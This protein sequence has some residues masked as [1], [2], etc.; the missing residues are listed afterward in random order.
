MSGGNRFGIDLTYK[1]SASW[2]PR[3]GT[4]TLLVALKK[5]YP[6]IVFD[7]DEL[8][9]QLARQ[10]VSRVKWRPLRNTYSDVT[11]TCFPSGLNS[12]HRAATPAVRVMSPSSSSVSLL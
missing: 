4:D 12:T 2:V 7:I 9:Y 5:G 11:A 1:K 8:N 10:R 6:S 3:C